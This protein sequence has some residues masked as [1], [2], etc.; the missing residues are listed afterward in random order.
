MPNKPTNPEA[1]PSDTV[2]AMLTPGEA[3]IPASVAMDPKYQGL[4]EEMVNEGRNRNDMAESIGIPVNH[5]T[6]PGL[7]SGG[8]VP[9]QGYAGGRPAVH[10][11]GEGLGFKETLGPAIDTITDFI[12]GIG[13]AKDVNAANDSYQQGDYW[14]AA[15]N[16]GLAAIGAVPI[17][18]DVARKGLKVIGG[19]HGPTIRALMESEGVEADQAIKYFK[20]DYGHAP[21]VKFDV[22]TPSSIPADNPFA[23]DI[24]TSH[25][26]DSY[27]RTGKV[28]AGYEGR[29][30]YLDKIARTGQ[31]PIQQLRRGDPDALRYMDQPEKHVNI[32]FG[33]KQRGFSKHFAARAAGLNPNYGHITDPT[34]IDRIAADVGD[35]GQGELIAQSTRPG[36]EMNQLRVAKVGDQ[37]LPYLYNADMGSAFTTRPQ[38]Y[39]L[40]QEN[41]GKLIDDVRKSGKPKHY[42]FEEGTDMVPKPMGAPPQYNVE[43]PDHSGYDQAEMGQG[44]SMMMTNA[45]H[46]QAIA[47]KEGA[48]AQ[49]MD[50]ADMAGQQKLQQKMAEKELDMHY[51]RA[52][53][54]TDNDIAQAKQQALTT[55]MEGLGM[56]PPQE[57]PPPAPEKPSA[58]DWGRNPVGSFFD[59]WNY[60]SQPTPVD[61]YQ[62]HL[63]SIN[64]YAD[65]IPGLPA[66]P[67]NLAATRDAG[68]QASIAGGA[69]EQEYMTAA[70]EVGGPA[71]PQL[72]AYGQI[73]QPL[74]ELSVDRL[75]GR[76]DPEAR[77]ELESRGYVNQGGTWAMGE[78]LTKERQEPHIA[79]IR[80]KLQAGEQ[81]T[82]QEATQLGRYN[83]AVEE[84]QGVDAQ[85]AQ[86][87][88]MKVQEGEQRKEM[89]LAKLNEQRAALG[90]PPMSA[91]EA[92]EETTDSTTT[93]AEVP[94]VKTK[95]V[96]TEATKNPKREWYDGI[97]DTFKNAFGTLINE[98]GLAEAAIVFGAN[99]LLGYDSDT[100]G[101]Q[102]LDWYNNKLQTERTAE[103]DT[104]KRQADLQTYAAEKQ[105]DAEIAAPG[106]AVKAAADAEKAD[107]QWVKDTQAYNTSAAEHVIKNFA[108]DT[109]HDSSGKTIGSK[110]YVTASPKRISAQHTSFLKKMGIT[111]PES[112]TAINTL[113]IATK[114][115]SD[116]ARR[117][118]SQVDNIEPWLY[119][120]RV[121]NAS[122]LG[123]A[124]FQGNDG[125]PMEATRVNAL[126]K[127]VEGG[128]QDPKVTEKV[129]GQ[130]GTAFNNF[131]RLPAESANGKTPYEK[132]V[133]TARSRGVSPF[134]Q[135][136]EQNK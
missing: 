102:A 99:K 85:A 101:K 6:V 116:Y 11:G 82:P 104:A 28:P 120:A 36:R 88:T 108:T 35:L 34:T 124:A 55:S 71:V 81:L 125:K 86:T 19:E 130:L 98:N 132:L 62:E 14:G 87:A 91:E 83:N 46:R 84:A 105:I 13:E 37:E 44:T 17:V 131:A 77:G 135:F 61:P 64:G 68:I 65:G 69:G 117:S 1:G 122:G 70:P 126:R 89:E 63:R 4:I 118:G 30:A 47:N 26:L 97:K 95:E 113:E 22:A 20:E 49:K 72:D 79:P 8:G 57:A 76:Q 136:V 54:Q 23:A 42:G 128:I 67:G 5:P 94:D 41:V 133:D 93:P 56:V 39:T 33:G 58:Q 16:L 111:D 21:D 40:G 106:A 107:R 66:L 29:A 25:A 129:W 7:A 121:T 53:A 9:P 38:E 115:A 110:L 24:M 45:K 12:P 10:P 51:K 80:A 15:G 3:V 52:E 60:Q 109:Q 74:N 92:V 119:S 127:A 96:M 31:S 90:I 114:Q 50:H 43:Q 48:N 100:A 27:K 78:D 59:K 103:A 18:G 123:S 112:A 32:D 2:P 73:P 75:T 134:F